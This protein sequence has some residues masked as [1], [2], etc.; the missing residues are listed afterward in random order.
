[1]KFERQ[2]ERFSV[3]TIRK[4]RNLAIVAG[5]EFLAMVLWFSASAV[6]PQLIVEWNLSASQQ[7]WMTMSVQ[8]GF[9][10]GALVSAVL[11][12]ADRV[13]SRLLFAISALV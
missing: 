10:V 8:I 11:N 3:Q 7:A 4:W 1:M 9:V 2:S 12:L 5:A 6:V 13:S